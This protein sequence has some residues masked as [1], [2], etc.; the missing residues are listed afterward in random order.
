[1]MAMSAAQA[2]ARQIKEVVTPTIDK[3]RIQKLT[4]GVHPDYVKEET[5]TTETV[6][7]AFLDGSMILFDAKV[8]T[9][10]RIAFV[11]PV[12]YKTIKLDKNFVSSGERS[13]YRYQRSC[14][15]DR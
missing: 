6:Y 9:D 13:G 4:E 12:F 8:P 14:W 15:H 10:G 3:Y 1:M 11:N 5:L 7:S 2:L